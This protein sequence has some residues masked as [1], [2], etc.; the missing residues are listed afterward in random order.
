MRFLTDIVLLVLSVLLVFLLLSTRLLM[1]G[2]HFDR[3]HWEEALGQNNCG[4]RYIHC[5]RTLHVLLARC[6]IG[7][8][9]ADTRAHRILFVSPTCRL[10]TRACRVPISRTQRTTP[11]ASS[12]LSASRNG[13][14][15]YCGTGSVLK[16]LPKCSLFLSYCPGQHFFL[17]C[18]CRAN[19][20]HCIQHEADKIHQQQQQQY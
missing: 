16:C 20:T 11:S 5:L 9:H 14:Y 4:S 2:E 13:S 7:Y 1:V 15:R 18:A 12:S 19:A 3:T 17:T 10:L 8:M 6:P